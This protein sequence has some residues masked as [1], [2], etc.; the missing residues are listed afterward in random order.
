LSRKKGEVDAIGLVRK[1]KKDNMKGFKKKE[2]IYIGNIYFT[3]V[4]WFQCHDMGHYVGQCPLKKGK[5][6]RHVVART[7]A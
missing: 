3:K 5:G 6:A 4:M 1:M 2:K 7:V